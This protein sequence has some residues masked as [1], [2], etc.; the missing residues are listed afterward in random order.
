MVELLY[1]IATS[2][3]RPHDRRLFGTIL[4]TFYEAYDRS[5]WE[6]AISILDVMTHLLASSDPSSGIGR[7]RSEHDLQI[8]YQRMRTARESF[9]YAAAS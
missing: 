2:E 3:L 9:R 4:R 5:D 7:R 8:A 6:L 1:G